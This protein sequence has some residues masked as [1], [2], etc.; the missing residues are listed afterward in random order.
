[1]PTHDI[2]DR[3]KSRSSSRASSASST[4]S[5]RESSRESSVRAPESTFFKP[6]QKLKKTQQQ[7]C[8]E[9]SSTARGTERVPPPSSTP[10]PKIS[11]A[12]VT[13]G[14]VTA[15]A[16]LLALQ[17]VLTRLSMQAVH[18]FGINAEQ[19][20]QARYREVY[21]DD[22]TVRLLAVVV[23]IFNIAQNFASQ[24]LTGSVDQGTR[25]LASTST[26][27]NVVAL[28]MYSVYFAGGGMGDDLVASWRVGGG[29]SPRRHIM[30]TLC[31]PS[32]IRAVALRAHL[33]SVTQATTECPS[34][35]SDDM[36]GY[37]GRDQESREPVSPRGSSYA[38]EGDSSPTAS[39]SS[40]QSRF[41]DERVANIASL[42]MYVTGFLG[43]VVGEA[44]FIR[45]IHQKALFSP[46]LLRFG[47][48]LL[49]KFDQN[50]AVKT[51]STKIAYYL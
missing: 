22:I 14:I 28:F 1:M 2:N 8:D 6:H 42:V 20:V 19:D 35:K 45:S 26:N 41:W 48:I 38:A 21:A 50:T 25:D 7:Q 17:F 51:H 18:F 16:K 49:I 34:P 32:L 12:R 30:W 24:I 40:W 23:F 5:A 10:P 13:L 36:R 9:K 46:Y 3:P 4:C 44:P 11:R 37:G 31:T 29:I 27:V 43:G 15:A 47:K 39:S 33:S